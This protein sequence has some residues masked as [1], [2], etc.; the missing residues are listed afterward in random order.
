MSDNA[1][2]TREIWIEN[3]VRGL[4]ENESTKAWSYPSSLRKK[5]SI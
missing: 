3:H 4:E 2:E 1:V 5:G